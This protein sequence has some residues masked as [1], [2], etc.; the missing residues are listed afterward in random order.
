MAMQ[1]PSLDGLD[2]FPKLL[3]HNAA[4]W[5]TDVAM[6]EKAFGI[7]NV[8]TWAGYRDQAR[9]I[10]LGLRSLGL[11]R[12]EVVSII[13][14]NRPNWVWSELAAH[15]LGCMTL[16]IYEDVLAAEAGYLVGYARAAVVVCEDEEQVD[17]ILDLGEAGRSV[18]HI[19]Y[20]DPRGM[21]KRDDPRLVAW[22]R[23]LAL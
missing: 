4:N 2:T 21:Q 12:G 9:L 8:V 7:W 19:V 11:R 10:A 1:L 22:D 6:R 5:P 20:H 15:C 14:R 13:G 17:K 23:L 16:G 18:R 3:L